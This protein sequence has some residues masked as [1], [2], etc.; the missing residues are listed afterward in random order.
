MV[1][2]DQCSGTRS[3]PSKIVRKCISCR[4]NRTQ[5]RSNYPSPGPTTK[6]HLLLIPGRILPAE[7][8]CG[9]GFTNISSSCQH[10]I[11]SSCQHIH[12][13]DGRHFLCHWRTYKNILDHLNSLHPTIQFTMELREGRGSSLPWYNPKKGGRWQNKYPSVPNLTPSYT[14]EEGYSFLL[15]QDCSYRREYCERGEAYKRNTGSWWI[16]STYHQ[17]SS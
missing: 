8:W 1:S 10:E 14:C 6:H 7:G 5:S 13:V 3:N 17:I 11:S 9:H 2:F 16:F 12:G 15:G 4:L